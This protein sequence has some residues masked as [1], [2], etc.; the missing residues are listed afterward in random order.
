[1]SERDELIKK[2]QELFNQGKISESIM[3]RLIDEVNKRLKEEKIEKR[4]KKI[5]LESISENIKIIGRD[6]ING[7][8]FDYGKEGF[9]IEEKED[10]LYIRS[11]IK[12]LS[13]NINIFGFLTKEESLGES[14][15]IFVPTD[16]DLFVSTISGDIN[17][18]N[19]SG[20]LKVKSVSGDI[21]VKNI[22]GEI[23]LYSISGDIDVEEIKGNF[24]LNTKSGDINAKKI[25]KS[26][27]IKSY[28]GDIEIKE[29][30]LEKGYFSTF[31]G[32]ISLLN[33]SLKES[34]EIKTISGD[35][36]LITP[37]KDIDII[38]DTKTGEGEI[39]YE[40]EKTKITKGEI[41]F[42]LK[43][44]ILNIKTLSGNYKIEV[45]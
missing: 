21:E 15:K 16:V 22:D 10:A 6:D 25:N 42:G 44:K 23:D 1:M 29:G 9:N 5:F 17:I 27:F 41:G 12:S 43:D 8:V 3:K 36:N 31:S 32:D 18:E 40:G 45:V 20:S 7:V 35:I 26:G 24:K 19:I 14:L 30:D 34:I 38:I 28:S 11:K 37:T 39:V 33:I 2:I 13:I 4:F